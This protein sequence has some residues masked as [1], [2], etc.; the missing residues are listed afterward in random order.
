MKLLLSVFCFMILSFVACDSEKVS[1]DVEAQIPFDKDAW[2]TEVDG[3]FP[4]RSQM[5]DHILYTDTLRRYEKTKV[6]ELLGEPGK[7]NEE[8]IYYLISQEKLGLWPI[9]TK[10]LVIKFTKDEK[11]GWIKLHG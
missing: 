6:L 7:S 10:T 5:L 9:Q 11:V 3:R 4:Y 1:N 2:Q 8:F